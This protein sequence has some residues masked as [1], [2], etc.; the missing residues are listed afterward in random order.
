ANGHPASFQIHRTR[1]FFLRLCWG[2]TAYRGHR[3]VWHNGGI[4]GF[5]AYLSMLPDDKMGIVILTNLSGSPLPDLIMYDVYD[6]LL[7][8]DPVDWNKRFEADHE[9][10]KKDAA[11]AKNKPD[12]V[13]KQGT[14]PS[15]DL[16]A[17]AGTFENP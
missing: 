3:H 2:V 16:A 7:N 13:R 4:D 11:E 15:H 5:Y 1:R 10:Q 6:H 17:Y 9:K 14:H 12:T 8:L